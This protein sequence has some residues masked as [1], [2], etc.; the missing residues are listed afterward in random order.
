MK[1]NLV[2]FVAAFL[3]YGP[4]KRKLIR[5][6]LDDATGPLV[7]IDR[8][9]DLGDANSGLASG[10]IGDGKDAFALRAERVVQQAYAFPK[11]LTWW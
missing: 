5:L 1:E 7:T 3:R 4:G 10:D 11:V 2:E 6:R 9:Q 8:R